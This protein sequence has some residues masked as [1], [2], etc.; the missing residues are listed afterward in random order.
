MLD[1]RPPRTFTGGSRETNGHRPARPARPAR[2]SPAAKPSPTRRWPRRLLSELPVAAFFIAVAVYATWPIGRHLATGV[3]GTLTDPLEN[4]WVFAWEAHAL[5]HQ[6]LQM[7]SANIFHPQQLTLAYTENLLGFSVFLAPI[8]WITHNA[9]LE[10]NVATILVY[11]IGGFTTYLL[12]YDLTRRRGPAIVAGV[13]F[14]VAPLRLLLVQHIVVLAMYLLPVALL[15][16]LRLSRAVDGSGETPPDGVGSPRRRLDRRWRLAIGLGVVVGFQMWTSINGGVMALT[17]VA[18]WIVWESYRLRGRAGRALLPALAGVALGLALSI[19]ALVPYAQLHHLHPEF[20]HPLSEVLSYSAAPT[21]YLAPPI[22]IGAPFV[23]AASH[24]LAH[25][26]GTS[27]I[28]GRFVK[29]GLFPG[30]FLSA[31]F[32]VTIVAAVVAAAR[33]LMGSAMRS[34]LRSTMRSTMRSPAR[35]VPP[36]VAE[37]GFFGAVAFTGFLLSLGPTN[38]RRLHGAPLPFDLFLKL[39]PAGGI[40]VPYRFG[41][42]VAFGMAVAAGLA[43]AAARPGVRRLL[44][45]AGLLFIAAETMPTT[46]TLVKAPPITAVHRMVAHTKGVVLALPATDLDAAGNPTFAIVDGNLVLNEF[47]QMYLS[48][49]NFRPMVNGI[50]SIVPGF[51]VDQMKKIQDFPTGSSLAAVKGWG[52]QTVVVELRL[53]PGT[54]WQDVAGRMDGWPGVR[55]LGANSEV[56]VYDISGA[57]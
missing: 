47:A 53:L 36:W 6:P 28:D 19:P 55:L 49:S 8:F 33:S 48:T 20:R 27:G 51:Y 30:F 35:R 21:Y 13:A 37:V 15:I 23:K 22:F 3:P 52:V 14:T 56:R 38:R 41:I 50:G 1:T 46:Y 5:L 31:A 34:A 26:W 32:L 45:V 24:F 2:Q 54:H 11:A 10:V 18:V 29:A 43:I 25:R 7:F 12:V 17:A 40:R 42:L 57:G 4:A 9:L 39:V 16:L 44:V